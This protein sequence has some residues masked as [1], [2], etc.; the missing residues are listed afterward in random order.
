MIVWISHRSKAEQLAAENK[1]YN[2]TR[3]PPVWAAFGI[4]HFFLAVEFLM[5]FLTDTV[6][7]AQDGFKAYLDCFQIEYSPC[8]HS[9]IRR[10]RDAGLI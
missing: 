5:M 2:D 8:K 1:Y 4:L 3:K 7:T 10:G 6:M 9:I